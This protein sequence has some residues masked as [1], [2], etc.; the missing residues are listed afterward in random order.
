[1]AVLSG[2]RAAEELVFGD[3]T[4]GAANDLEKATEIARQMVERYG[5]SDRLGFVSLSHPAPVFVGQGI[6]YPAAPSD[7]TASVIDQEVR[8]IIAAAQRE[9]ATIL[10]A[11]RP[12]LDRMAAALLD[13]ETLDA[14][15]IAAV[16]SRVPKWRRLRQGV[17][18]IEPAPTDTSSDAAA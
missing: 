16:F 3:P 9:A 11:H 6:G 4:T 2:G 1:L 8:D 17:G 7:E 18:V 10:T 14:A 12:A 13:K 5:M 15:E